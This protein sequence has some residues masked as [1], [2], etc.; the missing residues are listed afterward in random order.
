M[1]FA[2]YTFAVAGIY[3]ILVL[4]PQYFLIDRVAE[5]FP[6]AV[7]H[8]EFYYGFI[9][10]ALAFQLVFLIVA[11]DPAKYR[12]LMLAG[13]VEKLAFGIPVA[14]LAAAGRVGG[15]IVAGAS[16]DAVFGVLFVVSFFKTRAAAE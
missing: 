12:L 10:V 11:T 9:G 16:I 7:T 1:K 8:P 5:D 14:V 3:G 4:V 13:L 2:K 15:S 6:P